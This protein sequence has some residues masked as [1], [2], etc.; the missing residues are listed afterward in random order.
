MFDVLFVG[1]M[2]AFFVVSIAYTYAC[3]KL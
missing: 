1:M 2:V 3:G